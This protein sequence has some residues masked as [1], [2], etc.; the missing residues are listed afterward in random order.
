MTGPTLVTVPCFSGAPWHLEELTPLAGRPLR[1]MRLPENVDDIEA[2]ADFVEAQAADLDDYVLVG[3]SFG[4]V[5]SLAVAVRR[6]S[7]LRGLVLSGGFAADPVDSPWLRAKVGAARF[8]PGPLY[9]QVT[10]RFHAVSLASPHDRDG[11]VPLAKTD[12]RRLFVENTP[13][14]SY[15]ARAKAAFS[16]DYRSRLG[17]ITVPTLII[18][19]SPDQ[20]I[21][22]AHLGRSPAASQGLPRHDGRRRPNPRRAGRDDE[23]RTLRSAPTA[24][25]G[26]RAS[27][28]TRVL[29]V[30]PR[31]SEPSGAPPTQPTTRRTRRA[32]W[33]P[34]GHPGSR[35]RPCR[36]QRMLPPGHRRS[37][38]SIVPARQA[39]SPRHLARK[40]A[41]RRT[42]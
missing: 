18:T 39:E 5:V 34:G 26:P 10:L 12:F 28:G 19:P 8:R 33:R 35:W 2:Y 25:G 11:Q 41:L 4:A 29:R 13:W 17:Q 27:S 7:G 24:R 31:Q 22:A 40:Q 21:G 6:P 23:P 38:T 1:T 9:R 16:A 36:P 14:R 37:C 32:G 42:G 30:W 15:V 20:L 3:D